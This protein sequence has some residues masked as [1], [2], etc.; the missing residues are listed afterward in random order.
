MQVSIGGLSL[1][2]EAGDMSPWVLPERASSSFE[3]RPEH[4]RTTAPL[5]EAPRH[6]AAQTLQVADDQSQTVPRAERPSRFRF[7]DALATLTGED[8]ILK[9]RR[10]RHAADRSVAKSCWR[11]EREKE[12]REIPKSFRKA[13]GFENSLL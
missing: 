9:R 7:C 5:K 3:R 4:S 13:S 11:T 12:L 8:L 10:V 6:K 2:P 1:S